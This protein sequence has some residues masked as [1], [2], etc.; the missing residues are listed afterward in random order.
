MKF[1]PGKL[2]HVGASGSCPNCRTIV[3][4]SERDR[5][6][7]RASINGRVVWLVDCP[8]CRYI[9]KCTKAGE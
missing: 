9:I 6:P 8:R 1:T 3:I 7:T 5:N 4:L 2:E